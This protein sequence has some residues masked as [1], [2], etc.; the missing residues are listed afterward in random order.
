MA[1]TNDDD[2]G[3][4]NP[5]RTLDKHLFR[6]ARA[7]KVSPPAPTADPR[8]ARHCGQDGQAG[9]GEQ[10]GHNAR[11]R[12]GADS[13]AGSVRSARSD[14][15]GLTEEDSAAFLAAMGAVRRL[16]ANA[17]QA[18]VTGRPHGHGYEQPG[19][20]GGGT[21]PAPASGRNADAGRMD[22]PLRE[23][24]G[25]RRWL[26]RAADAPEESVHAASGTPRVAK[27]MARRRSR[28]AEAGHEHAPPA[29][30]A[31]LFATA[32][33][34][35]RTLAGK[36]RKVPP[37]AAPPRPAAPAVGHPLQD[38]MDGAVE[39]ALEFTAEYLEGH[40]VGL[41]ALT[42]GKLRAGQYSPEGHLDLHGMNTPQACEAMTGFLR[43]AYH[44]GL[45]T[46]LLIPGRGRNS[47]DG[48]GVLREKLRI[49][50]TQD[51]FKRV[52]L[53]FCTAR[54]AHGGAGALYVLLRKYKKSHGK[55]RWERT[56]SDPDLF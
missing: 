32:M 45:R 16:D 5:L 25:F 49:W 55:I 52:V 24:A 11:Q 8:H 39:F 26:E 20:R 37:E 31:G 44:K 2:F 9:Q 23:R 22:V 33:S 53:A 7:G 50:L 54:P 1:H 42:I 35:V 13:G 27:E 6:A 34:G 10:G 30:E 43:A 41:D 4:A 38:F 14:A 56:P 48:T 15:S 47:P 28:Q 17:V 3:S 51:P 12:P 19:A 29:D 21:R 18:S 40:V 46:V 36:G